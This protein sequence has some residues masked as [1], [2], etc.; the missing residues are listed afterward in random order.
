MDDIKVFH[1]QVVFEVLGEL[2]KMYL[3]LGEME[4]E[5]GKKHR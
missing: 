4:K 1:R 3:K 2:K 5:Y